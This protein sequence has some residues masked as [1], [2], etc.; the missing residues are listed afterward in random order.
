MSIKSIVTDYTM[1]SINLFYARVVDVG[2]FPHCTELVIPH[3]RCHFS[4][5]GYSPQNSNWFS[6]L[7]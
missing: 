5:L 7:C 1:Q 6:K 4:Q 2:L 3:S